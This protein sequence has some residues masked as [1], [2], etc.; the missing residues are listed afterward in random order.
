MSSITFNA[1]GSVHSFDGNALNDQIRPVN[2]RDGQQFGI[3]TRTGEVT[4]ANIGG[5]G[6]TR[7]ST[8]SAVTHMQIREVPRGMVAAGG[9]FVTE[10]VA[11]TLRRNSPELFT[12]P[13]GEA[14]QA[15][16]NAAAKVDADEAAETASLN[17]HPEDSI[18][19]S[20]MHFVSD[21]SAGDQIALLVAAHSGKQISEE[22]IQRVAEQMHV[23]P[24]DA[25]SKLE[26]VRFGTEQ[27]VAALVRARGGEP[28]KFSAWMRSHHNGAVLPAAQQHV[29]RRDLVGAWGKHVDAFVLATGAARKP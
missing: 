5:P 17:R 3:Q 14:R 29:L 8:A 22:L 18:E 27:Q 6:G 24:A 16:A 25:M 12:D 4:K 7:A 2:T 19:A 23:T 11:E 26:A 9:S 28:D 20:H 10:A 21:V 13:T 15:L 1:D